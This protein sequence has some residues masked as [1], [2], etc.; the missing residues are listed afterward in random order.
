MSLNEPS[1]YTVLVNYNTTPDVKQILIFKTA[2]ARD[3]LIVIAR[4]DRIV[5]N[6]VSRIISVVECLSFFW[7]MRSRLRWSSSKFL[8]P[9]GPW[10]L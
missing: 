1:S 5:I 6:S 7:G 10:E 4:Q 9:K 3:V 8:S 2:S